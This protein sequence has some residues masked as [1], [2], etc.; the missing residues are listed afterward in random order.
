MPRV[1][2]VA[3]AVSRIFARTPALRKYARD[4]VVISEVKHDVGADKRGN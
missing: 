2:S 3:R 4:G 1:L